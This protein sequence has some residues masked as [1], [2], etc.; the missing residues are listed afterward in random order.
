[1]FGNQIVIVGV[2]NVFGEWRSHVG[3]V[4]LGADHKHL[5]EQRPTMK[6][7]ETR[8]MCTNFGRRIVC[9]N[10]FECTHGRRTT[11]DDQILGEV[12]NIRRE[13]LSADQLS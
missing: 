5:T 4:P 10:G 11:T 8:A 3:H 2:P 6:N 13:F 9:T 7:D 1:M 12:G